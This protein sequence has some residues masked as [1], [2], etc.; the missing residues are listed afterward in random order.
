[1][2]AE[3]HGLELE[4]EAAKGHRYPVV[5]ASSGGFCSISGDQFISGFPQ[6]AA[7]EPTRA[8]GGAD[9]AN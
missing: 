3:S 2:S 4:Y 1:M 7:S 8:V 5:F 9:G 6:V